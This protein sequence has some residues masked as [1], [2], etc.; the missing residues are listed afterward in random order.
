M[1]T[2]EEYD[3]IFPLFMMFVAPWCRTK[4][5]PLLENQKGNFRMSARVCGQWGVID[6][7]L[8]IGKKTTHSPMI[9]G[10]L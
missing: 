10:I 3:D 8:F 1:L 4:P 2:Q 5:T 6:F 7:R 9:I